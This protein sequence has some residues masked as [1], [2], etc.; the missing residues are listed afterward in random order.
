MAVPDCMVF[1]SGIL[2]AIL[3]V[4]A[5]L[6][7]RWGGWLGWTLG[8]IAGILAVAG[9]GFLAFGLWGRYA[10]FPWGFGNLVGN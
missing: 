9:I 5:V 4:G 6:A 3:L 1:G 8:I 7:V 10:G 2:G